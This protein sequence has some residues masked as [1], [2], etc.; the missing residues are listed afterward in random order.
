MWFLMTFRSL[1]LQNTIRKLWPG[2]DQITNLPD[3][4]GE[5]KKKTHMRFVYVVSY[6]C[7]K[8]G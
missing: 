5:K 1:A 8:S 6:P 2:Q 7:E 4:E 3:L